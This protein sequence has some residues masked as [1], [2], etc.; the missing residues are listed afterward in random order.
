MYLFRKLRSNAKNLY[1]QDQR[2]INWGRGRNFRVKNFDLLVVATLR[3]DDWIFF[4][5]KTEV[6]QKN[7]QSFEIET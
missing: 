1:S 4:D 2:L 6:K 3:L 7:P 5:F